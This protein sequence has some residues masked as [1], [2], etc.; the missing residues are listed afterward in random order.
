[1]RRKTLNPPPT[2]Q[3]RS[4]NF[5]YDEC[6]DFGNAERGREDV[7]VTH[8]LLDTLTLASAIPLLFSRYL[9]AAKLQIRIG[10]CEFVLREALNLHCRRTAV[11]AYSS[12]CDPR[13][14]VLQF[15]CQL[16]SIQLPTAANVKVTAQESN[17]SV[18]E[19][20]LIA[21]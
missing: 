18:L 3:R 2:I 15:D 16:V 1:M 10:K 5:H 12:Q 14:R 8:F 4:S 11:P 7:H 21:E 13:G 17:E 19:M 9:A 6:G 20:H